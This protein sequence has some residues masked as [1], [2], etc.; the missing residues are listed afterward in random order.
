MKAKN[1]LWWVL[2][3]STVLTWCSKPSVERNANDVVTHVS[4]STNKKLVEAM[5]SNSHANTLHRKS[6][7]FRKIPVQSDDTGFKSE[8]RDWT[9]CAVNKIVDMRKIEAEALDEWD[10][11]EQPSEKVN[12]NVRY[13]HS[14]LMTLFME[15]DTDAAKEYDPEEDFFL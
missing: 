4:D 12:N 14:D 9:N 2:L 13:L 7:R 1:F 6:A 8:R 5:D 3:A 11:K 10:Q 15:E